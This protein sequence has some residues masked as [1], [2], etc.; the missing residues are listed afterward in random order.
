M[1]RPI[2]EMR[3]QPVLEHLP[4]FVRQAQQHVS[5][6]ALKLADA[7]PSSTSGAAP[8]SSRPGVERTVEAGTIMANAPSIERASQGCPRWCVFGKTLPRKRRNPPWRSS[9][10]Q[11][12]R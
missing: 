3:G 7:T 2:G 5:G 6:R 9:R 10:S 12:P 1:L 4:Q 8:A 11:D